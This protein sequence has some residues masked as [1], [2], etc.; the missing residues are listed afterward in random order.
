MITI[1]RGTKEQKPESGIH[2]WIPIPLPWKTVC[3]KSVLQATAAQPTKYT[4]AQASVL[5]PP[6][7]PPSPSPYGFSCTLPFFCFDQS[8]LLPINFAGKQMP[9]QM[10]M[11]AIIGRPPLFSR[12]LGQRKMAASL[13]WTLSGSSSPL[14]QPCSRILT[15]PLSCGANLL[16]LH[17]T[18]GL[19]L[20]KEISA[21]SRWQPCECRCG[22]VL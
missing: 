2:Q 11:S 6:S 9:S 12:P 10:L 22:S 18:P 3:R 19:L 13:L 21:T 14:S 15:F 5:L 20:C 7:P 8:G 17:S 4:T 1:G 16:C